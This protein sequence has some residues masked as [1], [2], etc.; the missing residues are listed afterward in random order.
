MLAIFLYLRS[1]H[2]YVKIKTLKLIFDFGKQLIHLS[3]PAFGA[4]QSFT[5]AIWCW[6]VHTQEFL[7]IIFKSI[8]LL[9]LS[10][11]HYHL[12][13][14]FITCASF[15]VLERMWSCCRSLGRLNPRVSSTA[16]SLRSFTPSK[17]AAVISQQ[18]RMFPDHL[19]LRLLAF[20]FMNIE[21]A[22]SNSNLINIVGIEGREY[23]N[24]KQ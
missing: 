7:S 16:S 17:V 11:Q 23:D 1:F 12:T 22:H 15:Q 13:F 4:I 3:W 24:V 20:W 9:H 8:N 6:C 5:R 19:L 21:N 18:F 10:F 14:S 2:K